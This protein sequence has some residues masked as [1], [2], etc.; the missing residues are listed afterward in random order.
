[1]LLQTY[2]QY[3]FT[4]W[5][6]LVSICLQ[7][8]NVNRQQSGLEYMRSHYYQLTDNKSFVGNKDSPLVP[9]LKMRNCLQS[10]KN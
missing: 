10:F 9:A 4:F 3:N 2:E 5:L 1:M 7:N 6:V 8:I